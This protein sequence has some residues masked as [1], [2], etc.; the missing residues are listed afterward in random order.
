MKL[1]PRVWVVAGLFLLALAGIRADG[2]LGQLGIYAWL[3]VFP[4]MAIARL[5]MPS[6]GVATR[7]TLGLLLSPLVSALAA[8]ILVRSG[9]DLLTSSR[10]IG[11]GGWLLFAGGEARTIGREGEAEEEAPWTR[12]LLLW[13]AAS[14]VFV[15]L[16]PAFNP[17]IR[18]RSD[19][20][21][22]GAIVQ[23]ILH[24][25][26]PPVDP[27]FIGLKLNYVWIYHLF[28][29]QLASFRGQDPFVFMAILNAVITG[30]MMSMMWQLAWNVWGRNERAARGVLV[31]FTLGLN[32]GA[33]LLWPLQLVRAFHG[34]V[35]GMDE[36]RRIVAHARWDST[37]VLYQLQAP[38][39]W[40]VH[41]W[42][43]VVLGTPLGIAYLFLLLFWWALARLW[44]GGSGRWLALAFVAGAGSV[45]FHS[46]VALTMLPVSFGAFVLA[47]LLRG[48]WDWLPAP[49]RSLA[50]FVA[51]ALGFASAL[52][53]LVSVASG[54][55]NENSGV[56]HRL[57]QI[58]WRMPLTIATSCAFALLFGTRGARAAWSE[59]RPFAAWLAI[60]VFGLLLMSLI[61]HLPEGNEHKFVWELFAGLALLGGPSFLDALV[62]WRARAGGTAFAVLF[63]LVFLVPSG[64]FLFG[65]LA[66]PG[67]HTAEALRTSP[68][69]RRF[70]DALRV[71][72]ADTDVFI[73]HRSRD[74]LNVQVPR[75][76]LAGTPFG[77]D[78]A[79]FPARDLG[80]RRELTDDLYGPVAK[81]DEDLAALG[82]IVERAR[83]VH[84][85]GR[86]YL[87]YREADFAPGDEPWNRLER[88]GA[89][90][91]RLD[92][93]APGFRSYEL[94]T[95]H[96]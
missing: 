56:Q 40:M 47:A 24:H 9:H 14:V 69:E 79:A 73:E 8:W 16:P 2:L 70:L 91:V 4:G 61:V 75:R 51:L 80:R 54:W 84:A 93:Q 81:L 68:E 25:G 11:M 90:R 65:F 67:R 83:R 45:L 58:G 35:S 63:A 18:I 44:L 23:E 62:R 76:L 7:W 15:A 42:D 29:A 66:D 53:Y 28:I 55:S 34:E 72:T 82:E 10:L 77:P 17:W 36:V 21:V 1:A 86:V 94:L 37:D 64:A 57:L 31:L 60:W 3:G 74:L 88:A 26:F 46:V 92:V 43:K 85:V 30:T 27:R 50:P 13:I 41:F 48:R 49:G 32:A 59:R 96:P 89:D 20:W 39:G 95:G 22:H 19:T 6:A 38:F 87:V 12:F 5:L 71:R 52:P 33:W 78:R